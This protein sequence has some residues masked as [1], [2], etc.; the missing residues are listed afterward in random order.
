MAVDEKESWLQMGESCCNT[1][2]FHKMRACGQQVLDLAEDDPDGMAMIA[3]SSLY[4]AAGGD[5]ES[6]EI[7]KEYIDK[8]QEKAPDNLR[9][10]LAMAEMYWSEFQIDKSLS[11]FKKFLRTVE[12]ANDD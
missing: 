3:E 10:M 11:A 2:E 7:A 6:L 5:E 4:L 12:K 1:G 9:G 8:L